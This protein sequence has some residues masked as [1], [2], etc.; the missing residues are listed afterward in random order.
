MNVLQLN[1]FHAICLLAK[2]SGTVH[3]RRNPNLLPQI[4][5]VSRSLGQSTGSAKLR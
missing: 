5:P 2:D 4:G 1:D 3:R